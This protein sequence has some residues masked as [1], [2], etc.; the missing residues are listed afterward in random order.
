[1][2]IYVDVATFHFENSNRKCCEKSRVYR[3]K[4]SLLIFSSRLDGRAV[5]D[6]NREISSDEIK[7][8][9]N[10][11]DSECAARCHFVERSAA[12][13]SLSDNFIW[14]SEKDLGNEFFEVLFRVFF[15]K[16]KSKQNSQQKLSNLILKSSFPKI[17][18]SSSLRTPSSSQI[19]S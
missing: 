7:S 3:E 15:N 14:W 5:K 18:Q 16:I 19:T 4:N 17:P 8:K 13:F 11:C 1:M 2:L 12:Q 6:T 9:W 10:E